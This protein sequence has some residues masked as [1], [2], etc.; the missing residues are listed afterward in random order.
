MEDMRMGMG[1]PQDQKQGMPGQP[2]EWGK[3][4]KSEKQSFEI[5]THDFA[6]EDA[7]DELLEAFDER[8][9]GFN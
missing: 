8:K 1:M 9:E 6:L 4:Y 7:E 5:M 2:K 3:L